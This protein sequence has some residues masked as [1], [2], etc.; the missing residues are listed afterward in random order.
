[1]HK[2]MDKWVA[3]VSVGS[4]EWCPG[5]DANKSGRVG[6]SVKYDQSVVGSI[7][8]DSALRLWSRTIPKGWRRGGR[9]NEEASVAQTDRSRVTASR[10]AKHA[11]E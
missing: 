5:G 6:G 7:P 11:L 3:G 1:M 9:V 10:F 2:R 4:G 8:S